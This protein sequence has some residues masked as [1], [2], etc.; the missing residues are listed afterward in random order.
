MGVDA[1][2]PLSKPPDRAFVAR[3]KTKM[4]FPRS[5]TREISPL[6]LSPFMQVNVGLTLCLLALP[7]IHASSG[8]APVDAVPSACL[9]TAAPTQVASGQKHVPHDE[10]ISITLDSAELLAEMQIGGQTD[11]CLRTAKPF[12]WLIFCVISLVAPLYL[13]FFR[14]CVCIYDTLPKNSIKII[15]GATLCF[16]G[17]PFIATFAAGEYTLPAACSCSC[18]RPT[19]TAVRAPCARHSFLSIPNRGVRARIAPLQP[20]LSIR[21]VG[22][23]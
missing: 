1:K 9:L 6:A 2:L 19:S 10:Q 4:S 13:C 21:W 23:H 16:F 8:C 17:G 5:S 11:L 22:R 20:R 15:F 14:A 12:L 7:H 3:V 18:S